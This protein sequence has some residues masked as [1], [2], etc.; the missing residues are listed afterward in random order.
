MRLLVTS[1]DAL[2]FVLVLRRLSRL[3]TVAVLRD[4]VLD[5]GS[6]DFGQELPGLDVI[7]DIDIALGDIAAGARIDVGLHK[8]ERRCGQCHVQPSEPLRHLLDMHARDE[9]RLPLG[10]GRDLAMLLVMPPHAECE[11]ADEQHENT[12]AEQPP[13]GAASR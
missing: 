12:K 7:A 5:L 9:V 11:S 13:S 3:Q 4:L 1:V 8:A 2:G 10:G 6:G